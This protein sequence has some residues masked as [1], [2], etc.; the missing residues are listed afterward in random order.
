MKHPLEL[1][2]PPALVFLL[3]GA[4]EVG[5]GRLPFLPLPAFTAIPVVKT[6]LMGMG[7][8]TVALGLFEFTRS[9][10]T[11]D[12]TKPET[13]SSLVESGIYR[14]T[15]NPVYLGML[16]ILLAIAVRSGDWLALIPAV[17]FVLW[18]NRFQIGP[19]ERALTGVF[20]A[21]YTEYCGRVRRW[22]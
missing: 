20:G 5:L 17:G 16:L 2:V 10:T 22:V 14:L 1:R 4:A 21:P 13:A 9:G 6:V 18:M 11:V 7:G 8:A 19:E 15:R 3:A 12:P